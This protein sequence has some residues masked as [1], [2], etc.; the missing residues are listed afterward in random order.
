M[1]RFTVE[2]KGFPIGT[3][4]TWSNGT[5][6]KTKDGWVPHSEGGAAPAV[7]PTVAPV[8]APKKPYTVGDSARLKKN[9]DPAAAAKV[10]AA[11]LADPT[12]NAAQ[13]EARKA[14][15]T[16]C[17]DFGMLDRDTDKPLNDFLLL[18][19]KEQLPPGVGGIHHWN[20]AIT[21]RD[22]SAKRA[23]ALLST[24]GGSAAAEPAYS[25]EAVKQLK[26]MHVL[27]HEA[28]HGH[29]PIRQENFKGR[30]RLLEEATTE[31]A[32]RKVMRDT[33]GTPWAWFK[34]RINPATGAWAESIGAY[35]SFCGSLRE[36]VAAA[37]K[38]KKFPDT[39]TDEQWEDFVGA[40]SV[41]MRR[42]PPPYDKDKKEF[43]KRFASSLPLTEE[44]IAAMGG[45]EAIAEEVGKAVWLSLKPASEQEKLDTLKAKAILSTASEAERLMAQAAIPS[46]EAA[47]NAAKGAWFKYRLT[48]QFTENRSA[49]LFQHL[50]TLFEAAPSKPN[51]D[52]GMLPRND[53]DLAIAYARVLSEDGRLTGDVLRDL[54]LLQDD[55]EGAIKR[56]AIAVERYGLKVTGTQE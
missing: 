40:T 13:R 46:Q 2:A 4:R 22:K 12:S 35:L 25:V 14:L 56:L 51:E 9:F 20:G 36:G 42:R 33:F 5:F 41:E 37:L 11:L 43:L 49:V 6:I 45:K 3:V 28:V 27:V 29:S 18:K 23:T 48:G 50:E 8:A 54:A 15:T 1:S 38:H 52:A 21:V 34:P 53:I 10:F 30:Y 26:G 39:M 24:T 19:A 47:L 55:S 7:A 16:L 44:Q 32:A 17:A 31:M